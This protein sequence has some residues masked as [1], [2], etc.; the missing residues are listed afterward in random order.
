MGYLDFD[1]M[2]QSLSSQPTRFKDTAPLRR[3][4]DIAAVLAYAGYSSKVTATS[5]PFHQ[6]PPRSLL[7]RT[8]KYSS[9]LCS[10]VLTTYELI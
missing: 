6:E 2:L 7:S 8:R 9:T 4:W 3:L 5:T 10:G 1:R